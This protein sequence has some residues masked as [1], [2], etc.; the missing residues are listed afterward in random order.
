M[1]ALAC[2]GQTK[3]LEVRE[4]PLVEPQTETPVADVE[5]TDAVKATTDEKASEPLPAADAFHVVSGYRSLAAVTLSFGKPMPAAKASNIKAHLRQM[6]FQKRSPVGR[7]DVFFAEHGGVPKSDPLVDFP[8]QVEG[9][10]KRNENNTKSFQS[11]FYGERL[12]VADH[13]KKELHS[14]KLRDLPL[15]GAMLRSAA[16]AD[17][18]L[19]VALAY[20]GYAKD[21]GGRTGYIYAFDLAEGMM[22]W[23]TP[24]LRNNFPQIQ[25]LGPFLVSG[26]G[27]TKEKDFIY[28]HDRK[29]GVLLAKKELKSGPNAIF[30]QGDSVLVR[31]Y[32][33]DY[34]F[35]LR[36]ER[37]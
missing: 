28:V 9:K 22:R 8:A 25:V 5:E 21:N 20:N 32:G 26:Y 16:F 18:M 35:D 37:N 6:D 27:F 3:Q 33:H 12:L 4:E 1:L 13:E 2:G 10:Q 23:S 11:A 30:I 31:A 34:V 19:Y 24:A 36:Q 14:I 7:S 17:G 29:N 15:P